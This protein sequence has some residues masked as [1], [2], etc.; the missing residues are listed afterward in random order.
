MTARQARSLHAAALECS[1]TVQSLYKPSNE[2]Q[3]KNQDRHNT[4]LMNQRCRAGDGGG[5]RRDCGAARCVRPAGGGGGVPAPGAGRSVRQP[6]HR[7]ARAAAC[8][9]APSLLTAC[10]DCSAWRNRVRRTDVNQKRQQPRQD[11]CLCARMAYIAR[12]VMPHGS[13]H[14]LPCC[15]QGSLPAP[16]PERMGSSAS[17]AAGRS[18]PRLFIVGG[19]DRTDWLDSV[20]VFRP[21]ADGGSWSTL[22]P[23]GYPRSFSAAAMLGSGLYVVGGG[24]G[25]DWFDSVLRCACPRHSVCGNPALSRV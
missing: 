13:C 16:G 1:C 23:Q 17:G 21:G 25:E 9:G 11:G 20:D 22:A 8:A 15:M 12:R 2:G 3:A 6:A 7:A 18:A 5:A 10:C 14:D 24:N 19:H 4:W